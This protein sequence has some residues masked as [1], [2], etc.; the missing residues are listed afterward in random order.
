MLRPATNGQPSSEDATK[1]V[2][3]A[4]LIKKLWD[5]IKKEKL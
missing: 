4:C 1:T 3:A 2:V 5:T